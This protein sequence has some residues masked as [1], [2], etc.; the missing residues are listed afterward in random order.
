MTRFHHLPA[1]ALLLFLLLTGMTF[2]QTPLALAHTE[3]EVGP[4]IVVT[5]WENEPPIVG[6]RNALVLYVTANGLPAVGLEAG[7]KI[8]VSYAGRVF[9]GNLEPTGEPGWYRMPILPTVRGKYEAQLTGSVAGVEI[10]GVIEPEEVL[11]ASV[12]QFPEAP[13][14]SVTLAERLSGLTDE[15]KT[16]QTLAIA[17]IALG[18]IALVL[19]GVNLTRRRK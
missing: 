7:L 5:G 3:S 16:V 17:G 15:I 6:E 19:S 2:F 12:L 14:D 1:A 8:Q 11:P 9:L 4:Y 10:N 13:P 18:I